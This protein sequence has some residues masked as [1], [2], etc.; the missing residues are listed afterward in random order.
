MD[1]VPDC[2]RPNDDMT[3]NQDGTVD[4]AEW[5]PHAHERRLW[6]TNPDARDSGGR[7]PPKE[8]RLFTEVEVWIPPEIDGIAPRVGSQTTRAIERAAADVA[9][10]D[11]S[12]VTHLRALSGFLLRSESIASSKIERV[13]ATREELSLAVA[14]QTTGRDALATVGAV[15]AV[16]GLVES[17]NDQQPITLANV[18]TA[19]HALM[20]NDPAEAG[21]AG[22]VRDQQSWIGG[23]DWSPRNALYVPPPPAH[24]DRLFTDLVA[25]A[26]R[27]DLPAFTQAA[28]VHAQFESIHPY[29]DGNG[30]IGRAL[31]N[32]ILRRRR[33]TTRTVVPIASVMLANP[34]DYFERLHYYRDGDAEQFVRYLAESSAL[35]AREAKQSGHALAA[36]PTQ[37]ADMIQARSHSGTHALLNALLD[38]PVLTD[39]T[40]A[41]AAGVSV[42]RIYK[43]LD[44]LEEAGIIS[45]IT[46]RKRNRVWQ[47]DEV[48]DELDRLEER[49]GKRE[50]PTV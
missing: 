35:A 48:L 49:I 31:I 46:G 1:A 44:E 21:Y 28:I 13:Y 11:Q 14:G 50:R 6:R 42:G 34:N 16:T 17:A 3:A 27:D 43:A 9:A 29:T 47:V 4:V 5:P 15:R 22:R 40:A 36:L 37:W 8:D 19:H 12:A 23:S 20:D 33:V 38:V 30:R 24:I 7:R 39:A 2:D 18:H 10:L 45:E 32:T 25:A 41:A 26:N